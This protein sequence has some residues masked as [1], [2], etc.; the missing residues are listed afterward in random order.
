MTFAPP[1][2][3]VVTVVAPCFNQS[4]FL[5]QHLRSV[6]RATERFHEVVVVDDGSTN[7]QARR[8]LAGIAATSPHQEVR[9]LHQANGGLAAARNAG[10]RAS[11]GEFVKFLDSDDLLLPNALDLQIDH[12]ESL[13]QEGYREQAHSVSIGDY[14]ILDESSATLSQPDDQP[15]QLESAGFEALALGWE[16]GVTIPIHCG[17]FRRSAFTSAAPFEEQL[18][19]KEDW[20][21]WMGLIAAGAQLQ[22]LEQ[23]VAVYRLHAASMTRASN[24]PNALN[25]LRAADLARVQFPDLFDNNMFAA[26]QDHFDTFYMQ[27]IWAELGPSL[28]WRFFEQIAAREGDAS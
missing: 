8:D 7:P 23:E 12:L 16:R 4:H 22:L 2:R 3:P 21:F 25:W 9:V 5:D 11:R 17:L 28:P 26:A 13:R 20:L 14:L 18:R 10:F 24:I 19:S 27:R 6:A 15:S 1:T